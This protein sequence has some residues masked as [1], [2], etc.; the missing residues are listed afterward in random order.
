MAIEARKL[1]DEFRS[2][3]DSFGVVDTIRRGIV[4]EQQLAPH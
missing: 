3:A 1:M 2:E 4:H